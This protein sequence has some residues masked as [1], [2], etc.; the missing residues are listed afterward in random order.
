MTNLKEQTLSALSHIA[1]L[2]GEI[3]KDWNN[4]MAKACERRILTLTLQLTHIEHELST[5]GKEA[6]K[7]RKTLRGFMEKVSTIRG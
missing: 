7:L 5:K 3:S 6:K 2:N 1:H 4:M